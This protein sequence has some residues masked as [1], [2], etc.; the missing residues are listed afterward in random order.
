MRPWIGSSG[1]IPARLWA[2]RSAKLID[3]L[4]QLRMRFLR[5]SRSSQHPDDSEVPMT[6]FTESMINEKVQAFWAALQ[7]GEQHADGDLLF[8]LA[9]HG[10]QLMMSELDPTREGVLIEP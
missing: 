4:P 9:G 7:R 8:P 5:F 1:P 2:R 6:G 10:L 3:A